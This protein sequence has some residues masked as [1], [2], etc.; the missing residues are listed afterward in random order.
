MD[1]ARIWV[2]GFVRWYNEEHHHS[3]IKFVSPSQ[4]HSGEDKALLAKRHEVYEA[5]RAAHPS[6]WSGATRNWTPPSI[7]TLNPD[8][9]SPEVEK[10]AA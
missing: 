6:R 4:R 7:V 8:R 10:A 1:A 9:K 5:A 2:L 3:A